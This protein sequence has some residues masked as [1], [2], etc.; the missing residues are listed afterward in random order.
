MRISQLA[1]QKAR[2]ML[3]E[4]EELPPVEEPSLEE[5]DPRPEMLCFRGQSLALVRHF[6]ELSC[7]IGR[8]PSLLGREFFRARVTH[9]AIPSF[10]EQVVFVRDMELCLAKLTDEHAEI[11]TLVGLYDFTLEEV[12]EM[13]RYSKTVVHRWFAEAL[14]ALSEIFLAA[15]LLSEDR[16]DRRQ[17]QMNNRALPADVTAAGKKPPQSVT[18]APEERAKVVDPQHQPVT[19]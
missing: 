8:L 6:F 17:R 2:Q 12:G 5:I 16:P 3:L 15:G 9:H 7:Q 13:L 1:A 11:M 18:I 19:A 4:H 10:E 14:D